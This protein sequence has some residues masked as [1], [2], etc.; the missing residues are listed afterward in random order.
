M[1]SII[2]IGREYGSGGLEI[3]IKRSEQLG[4]PFLIKKLSMMLQNEA[5][6]IGNCLNSSYYGIDSTVEIIKQIIQYS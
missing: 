4:R 6:S 5:I 1:N 3:G 2:T